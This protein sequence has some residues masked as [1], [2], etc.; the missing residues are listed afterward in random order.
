[1]MGPSPVTDGSRKALNFCQMVPKSSRE[2]SIDDNVKDNDQER[3]EFCAVFT[4][5]LSHPFSD[6]E[7]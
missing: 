6:I 5:I 1:M 2:F 7:N 4:M 3:S